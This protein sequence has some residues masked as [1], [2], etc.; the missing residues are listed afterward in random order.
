MNN[1]NSQT[2]ILISV[3]TGNRNFV[4]ILLKEGIKF[5]SQNVNV[6]NQSFVDKQEIKANI[7]KSMI[8][9]LLMLDK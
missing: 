4:N 8:E 2:T 3:E 6:G 9:K 1:Q 7:I 5:R